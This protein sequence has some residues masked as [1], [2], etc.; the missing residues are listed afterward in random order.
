MNSKQRNIDGVLVRSSDT[1][2]TMNS[3]N[4]MC[5]ERMNMKH[6]IVTNALDVVM[7]STKTSFLNGD[8]FTEL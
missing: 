7:R 8:A 5:N 4:I 2:W 6:N 3:S 1:H